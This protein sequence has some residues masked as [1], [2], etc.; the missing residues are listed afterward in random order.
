MR[1]EIGRSPQDNPRLP[2]VTPEEAGRKAEPAR[3]AVA[4]LHCLDYDPG[5]NYSPTAFV[6]IY[7]N[8]D[9]FPGICLG[10]VMHSMVHQKYCAY[11]SEQLESLGRPPLTDDDPRESLLLEGIICGFANGGTLTFRADADAERLL[12]GIDIARRLGV[13]DSAL[14]FMTTHS[15]EKSTNAIKHAG[16]I[17]QVPAFR[18]EDE[19]K[20]IRAL[21]RSML[22]L[23]SGLHVIYVPSRGERLVTI[24]SI[25]RM[26]EV[27]DDYQQFR[28]QVEEIA[29]GRKP[30]NTGYNDYE[31]LLVDQ[32][33]SRDVS[34]KKLAE[35]H[36]RF[37]RVSEIVQQYDMGGWDPEGAQAARAALG[38]FLRWLESETPMLFHRDD[39]ENPQW[40]NIMYAFRTGLV[41]ESWKVNM[42]PEFQGMYK[43]LPGGFIGFI[44]EQGR[45]RIGAGLADIQDFDW[46]E[47][48]LTNAGGRPYYLI[49][50][51]D[52]RKSAAVVSMDAPGVCIYR[53]FIFREEAGPAAIA[54]LNYALERNPELA[55]AYV[56]EV[57]DS[58]SSRDSLAQD[59]AKFWEPPRQVHV[60]RYCS[61]NGEEKTVLSRRA[62]Y[63]AYY[64]QHVHREGRLP[65]ADAVKKSAAIIKYMNLQRMSLTELGASAPQLETVMIPETVEGIGEVQVEHL[66]R[67]FVSGQPFNRL[68]RFDLPSSEY[69][70]SIAGLTGELAMINLAS[71]REYFGDNDEVITEF[72]AQGNPLKAGY[73]DTTSAFPVERTALPLE[74]DAPLYA[75][76]VAALLEGMRFKFGDEVARTAEAAFF[77]SFSRTFLHLQKRASLESERWQNRV[78]EAYA[79]SEEVERDLD[80]RIAWRQAIDTLAGSSAASVTAAI[81]SATEHLRP[82]YAELLQNIKTPSVAELLARGT[83]ELFASSWAS[84]NG[85]SLETPVDLLTSLRNLTELSAEERLYRLYTLRV[86]LWAVRLGASPIAMLNFADKCYHE[87]GQD[88]ALARAR[89]A[90]GVNKFV[91]GRGGIELG[92]HTDVAEHFFDALFQEEADPSL[93]EGGRS[94]SA[95]ERRE[96]MMSNSFFL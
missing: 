25:R 88:L 17:D 76:H 59:V 32:D 21:Q 41:D 34:S 80:F 50:P 43:P 53:R 15:D 16:R 35:A 29:S 23:E 64:W 42:G 79:Q 46:S 24:E 89:F 37:C 69:A 87:E 6:N 95:K 93:R 19:V 94:L 48:I 57:P 26:L 66:V 12:M 63:P 91:L 96:E 56:C 31:F 61:E 4:R 75:S 74:Q 38:D 60:M 71:R 36:S 10:E 20:V 85:F 73:A 45:P 22:P 90:R 82:V 62:Q 55:Y 1:T 67:E 13:P 52:G 72:D 5:K 2:R 14:R 58:L 70:V 83:E 30:S 78:N 28:R 39:I 51:A 77:E 3:D 18:P 33:L 92:L 8:P 84:I 9:F 7:A 44:D 49:P 27:V 86:S 47:A 11:V 40:R 68:Q 65:E 81:R 54:L